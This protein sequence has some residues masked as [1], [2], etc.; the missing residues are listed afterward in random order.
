MKKHG[1]CSKTP[2]VKNYSLS[3][4]LVM[5]NMILPP[6]PQKI[7]RRRERRHISAEIIELRSQ[8]ATG[9]QTPLTVKVCVVNLSF[10]LE[11]ILVNLSFRAARG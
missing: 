1:W 7:A 4:V 2:G 6:A 10:W 5:I 9:L 8:W 11:D 3:M